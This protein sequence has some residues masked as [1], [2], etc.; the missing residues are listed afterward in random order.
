MKRC[1]LTMSPVATGC[2]LPPLL[3]RR[4][5]ALPVTV[6]ST[7]IWTKGLLFSACL[8]V[9][10]YAFKAGRPCSELKLKSSL[11]LA[12]RHFNSTGRI[13]HFLLLKLTRAMK[14]INLG[15]VSATWHGQ[16]LKLNMQRCTNLKS[17]WKCKNSN[18]EHF[19]FDVRH[20]TPPSRAP[21]SALCCLGAGPYSEL[22]PPTNG[23]HEESMPSHHFH[24][25]L[26]LVLHLINLFGERLLLARGSFFSSCSTWVGFEAAWSKLANVCQSE[27][28][29]T[30]D[31]HAKMES[32][33]G[34]HEGL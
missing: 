31:Q 33:K 27:S 29:I 16:F 12:Q 2:A 24:I 28:T 20:W 10:P 15:N 14:L 25:W 19:Y 18:R 26:C 3:N 11:S 34:N 6:Y 30:Y 23:P 1:I 8:M 21:I 4:R 22:H 32:F 5:P 7:G 9:T 17:T 13:R